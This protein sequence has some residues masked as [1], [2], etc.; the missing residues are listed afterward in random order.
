MSKYINI[1]EAT[2]A[3]QPE[4]R[5][6]YGNDF[7][8]GVMYALDYLKA[9]DENPELEIAW[10]DIAHMRKK[11]LRK[12]C[13]KLYLAAI[14]RD[15]KLAKYEKRE[16]AGAVN[17]YTAVMRG[18]LLEKVAGLFRPR[19]GDNAIEFDNVI[20]TKAYLMRGLARPWAFTESQAT[21][22]VDLVAEVHERFTEEWAGVKEEENEND[23]HRARLRSPDAY[24]R[25]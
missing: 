19:E 21:E 10:E 6:D 5:E 16:D 15:E 20:L 7:E 18:E 9:W 25:T 24:T 22:F 17:A 14:A 11:Q 2:I 23:Y 8:G 13:E 4:D 12:T 3:W 1:E